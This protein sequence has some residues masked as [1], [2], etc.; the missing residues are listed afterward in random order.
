MH[1]SKMGTPAPSFNWLRPTRP[2]AFREWDCI[3]ST[4]HGASGRHSVN[5]NGNTNE[6]VDG[7]Y[8]KVQK[9]EGSPEQL[10]R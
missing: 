2:S 7:V 1:L 5:T 6:Q 3:P 8:A 10:P 9:G 4:K